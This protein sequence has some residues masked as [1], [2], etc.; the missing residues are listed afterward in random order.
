MSFVFVKTNTFQKVS[1]FFAYVYHKATENQ[2]A[3]KHDHINHQSGQCLNI[4]IK[5]IF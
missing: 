3:S 2:L 5:P 4:F 1:S